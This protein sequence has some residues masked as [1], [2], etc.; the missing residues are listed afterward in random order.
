MPGF[1]PGSFGHTGAGA[2]LGIG[3]P[4]CGVGL[5]YITSLMRDIGPHGDP[6]WEALIDAVRRCI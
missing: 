3:D 6:R 1:G 2:R 5:G 4:E